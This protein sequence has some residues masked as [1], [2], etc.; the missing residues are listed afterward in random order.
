M[1]NNG[2]R[3]GSAALDA[4]KQTVA[5]VAIIVDVL[6]ELIVVEARRM[7]NLR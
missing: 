7:Q 6:V 2:V 5:I 3:R 4:A 1:S